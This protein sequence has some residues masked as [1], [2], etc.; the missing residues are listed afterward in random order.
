MNQYVIRQAM[1]PKFTYN[2]YNYC[3][4]IHQSNTYMGRIPIIGVIQC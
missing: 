4:V 1:I 3:F 2:K